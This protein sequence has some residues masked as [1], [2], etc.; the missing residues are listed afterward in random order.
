MLLACGDR[1]NRQCTSK[2]PCHR[3]L[4]VQ[5]RADRTARQHSDLTGPAPAHIARVVAGPE[6]LD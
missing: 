5:A 6:K 2:V 1:L 4:L 3:A